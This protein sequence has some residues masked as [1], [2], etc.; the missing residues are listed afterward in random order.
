MNY[1][2][3]ENLLVFA[4]FNKTGLVL[5]TEANYCIKMIFDQF[6]LFTDRFLSVLKTSS[7][8]IFQ[9]LNETQ[10]NYNAIGR[11]HP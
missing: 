2:T 7:I 1:K 6:H 5:K 10:H 11:I 9:S 4:G 8:L 3:I